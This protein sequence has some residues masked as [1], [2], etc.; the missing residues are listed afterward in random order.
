MT[1]EVDATNWSKYKSGVFSNC[2]KGL[3]HAV[4]LVGYNTD[5]SWIVKNSW[6]TTWGEKGFMTLSPGN[7]CGI[8]S[9]AGFAYW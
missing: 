5:D 6:G 7:T 2:A 9:H 1:V 3:N 4:L 8:I